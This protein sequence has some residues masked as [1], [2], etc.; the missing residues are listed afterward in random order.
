MSSIYVCMDHESISA[1]CVAY[2]LINHLL[3]IFNFHLT[4]PLSRVN[5]ALCIHSRII[6]SSENFFFKFKHL[7]HKNDDFS[8]TTPYQ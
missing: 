5:L 7:T 3:K 2:Q 8:L 1:A 4:V 6:F